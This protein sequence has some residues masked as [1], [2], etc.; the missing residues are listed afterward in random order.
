MLLITQTSSI[1]NANDL[2]KVNAQA[3]SLSLKE[4]SVRSNCYFTIKQIKELTIAKGKTKIYVSINKIF[5]DPELKSLTVALKNICKLKIDG[6]IYTD[7]GVNQILY[8]IKAPKSIE[9]IYDSITLATNY[10]QFPFYKKNNI[11]TVLLPTQLSSKNVYECCK[12]KKNIK[13]CLQVAGHEYMMW[14]R[15]KLISN[16]VKSHKLDKDISNKKLF[17]SE[18]KRK[19]PCIITEDKNGT[20]VTTGYN[21]NLLSEIP[22]MIKNGLDYVFLN[23]YLHDDEW[24]IAFY[25]EISKTIANNVYKPSANFIELTKNEIQSEG[26][27]GSNLKD[28]IYFSK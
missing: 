5:F 2:L 4:F 9:Q 19:Q 20:Y 17:I 7:L 15:W 27:Y 24:T 14:S 8:E 10:G 28:L 6:I 11:S 3:I 22:T 1:K 25:N 26:F 13:L 18:Q 12:N 21:L 23:T 16:F